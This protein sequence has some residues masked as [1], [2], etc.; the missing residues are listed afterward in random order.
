[1][2]TTNSA[3]AAGMC[4]VSCAFFFGFSLLLV[5]CG[6]ER[7]KHF[8]FEGVVEPPPSAS[9][10]VS[11]ASGAPV[12]SAGAVA[13]APNRKF[14]QGGKRTETP[15]PAAAGAY[16][17]RG[18]AAVK[19]GGWATFFFLLSLAACPA[20]FLGT[21]KVVFKNAEET[22]EGATCVAAGILLAWLS[23]GMPAGG[24]YFILT[25]IAPG[26]VNLLTRGSWKWLAVVVA[27]IAYLILIFKY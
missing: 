25:L 24:A 3:R 6:P 16:A 2:K 13:T 1:M 4:V 23:W 8:S 5:A 15:P 9:V 12:A 26:V 7:G 14:H 11:L 17:R 10:A 19:H 18:W 22:V 20:I 21:L 27:D